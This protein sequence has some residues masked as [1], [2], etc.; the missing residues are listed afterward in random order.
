MIGKS[1]NE[2]FV[3]FSFEVLSRNF[4]EGTE[5]NHENLRTA[6]IRDENCSR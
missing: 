5:K 4:L 3:I 2:E 6:G 1:M